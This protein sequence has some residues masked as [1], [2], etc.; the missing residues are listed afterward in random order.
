MLVRHGAEGVQ[1]AA[2]SHRHRVPDSRGAVALAGRAVESRTEPS[3]TTCRHEA[4]L[5]EVHSFEF[6]F[7][8]VEG[9]LSSSPYGHAPD[10][11]EED[12]DDVGAARR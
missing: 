8:A 12:L 7:Q 9:Y 4:F 1:G 5:D 11:A 6:W 2:R 3:P 10:L